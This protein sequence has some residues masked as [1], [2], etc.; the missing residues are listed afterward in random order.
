MHNNS[1]SGGVK[2]E[3]APDAAL[4]YR[5]QLLVQDTAMSDVS[6]GES[7]QGDVLVLFSTPPP[8]NLLDL[9]LMTSTQTTR[10]KFLSFWQ[11]ACIEAV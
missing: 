2:F 10:E 8:W 11:V 6:C 3:Q 4:L 9:R 7:L 1:F 5:V